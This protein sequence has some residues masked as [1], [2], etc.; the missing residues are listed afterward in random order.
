MALQSQG[1][2]QVQ[3]QTQSLVL[4]PQLRQSL[5]ILQVPALEL[6]SAILEELQTN[7]LL[8][9]VG[10]ND[11][12]LDSD[13]LEASPD[14]T[15]ED[16]VD[17]FENSTVKEKE[18]K[19]GEEGEDD[20]EESAED[21]TDLDFT[22]EFSVL[23]EMQEDLRE[24]YEREYEG[25]AQLGNSEAEDKRKFF[26]D[27]L[28]AETSLQEH[29][30]GQLKMADTTDGQVKACEYLIGSLDEKGFLSIPLSEIG[31]ISELPLKDLQDGLRILQSFEPVGI[32]SVD[33]QDCL[34]KQMDARGWELSLAYRIVSEQF[35][36]LVRRRVPELSRKLSQP[37]HA[38]HEA[39]K[40]IAELD[41]APGKRF[42]EDSNQSVA[43]DAEVEKVGKE[44]VIHLNNDYVPRLRLNKTYKELITKG[45][46]SPKE[47]EYVRN[48]MRAGKFLI[49]SIEQRQNTIERITKKIL[50]KQ[51]DFFLHGS[52]KLH[53]MTM[54]Q[55]AEE[56]DVHETTVSRATAN[57]YLRTSHGLFPFKYFFTPGYSG[58]DGDTVSNTSVKEIIGSIIEQ[59]DPKKPLSDRAIVDKL[60]EK[61]IK[62]ARRTV[63]KYREELGISPTNLRRQY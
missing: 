12:S 24:H 54:A 38:I 58:K 19:D 47:K 40:Q 53:P 63:A 49:N 57:K 44:W 36:L 59:E 48:Q 21:L 13:N 41:P 43:A 23:Q 14:E 62:L 61:D 35:T 51:E 15:T 6:R 29:L 22:D 46:L 52:S 32:A 3:K 34:L 20:W 50:E 1:L 42:S 8:E 5:K 4:A 7:P 11:E 30:L 60:A 2:R 31:L 27:S 10:S 33:L 18:E 39:L 56:I 28:V 17:E 26:F 45:T 16:Q 25:E 9:E 37:T 55:V